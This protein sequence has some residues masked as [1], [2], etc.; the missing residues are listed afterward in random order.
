MGIFPAMRESAGRSD[1]GPLR[2]YLGLL[3]RRVG[4]LASR[5][6]ARTTALFLATASLLSIVLVFLVLNDLRHRAALEGA[7]SYASILT[8]FREYYTSVVVKRA[9]EGGLDISTEYHE[10]ESA[11][12]PPA[13]MTIE[14][15]TWMGDLIEP[16]GFRF[17][18]RYPFKNRIGGGPR[19]G[20]EMEA[21]AAAIDRG[22][23]EYLSVQAGP[24]S[25]QPVLHFAQPIAMGA[26]CVACHNAHPDS[27]RR[28]W[29]V[30]DIRGIQVVSLPLPDLLP[31]LKHLYQNEQGLLFLCGAL[32]IGMGLISLMLLALMRGLRRAIDLLKRRNSQLT[33]A[34]SLA[35]RNAAAKTRIMNN[36]SHELRTPM[37]AIVGFS[38]MM[39]QEALGPLGHARYR[40]YATDVSNSARQL[41]SIIENMLIMAD[42]ENEQGDLK[43]EAINTRRELD[44]LI[45]SIQDVDNSANVQIELNETAHF[46]VLALSKK[47]FRQ[48][49]GNLID[50]VVKHAGAG[51]HAS[52]S[53]LVEDHSVVLSVVDDGV[54]ITESDMRKI[55]QPFEGV[56]DPGL[57]NTVGIG[58]GLNVVE[59]L[60]TQLGGSLDIRSKPN[61]GLAAYVY[62]PMKCLIGFPDEEPIAQSERQVA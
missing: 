61:Q 44:D 45:G 42:I 20:F 10:T 8:V 41:M 26:G 19:T 55:L 22:E 29:K 14:I 56:A 39:S 16:G 21:L 50:N 48:I 53:V 6:P 17:L 25:G 9:K 4:S 23:K 28:D 5:N 36:V 30:G 52:V 24:E 47:A 58:L 54:G 51:A 62:L 1:Q 59:G 3:N 11:L 18:S 38:D 15:G 2:R 57:A 32:I 35:R 31:S 13:T 27:V 37:N 12:P 34:N 49:A 33:A 46:P 40:G 60:A 7:R 43:A